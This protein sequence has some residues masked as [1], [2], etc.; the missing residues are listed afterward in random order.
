MKQTTDDAKFNF[1]HVL[2]FVGNLVKLVELKRNK[3]TGGQIPFKFLK[4]FPKQLCIPL[5]DSINLAR[6]N[7]TF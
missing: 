1:Q 3:K 2:I 4:T 5:S 6:L 7:C